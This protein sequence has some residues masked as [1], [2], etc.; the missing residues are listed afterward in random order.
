MVATDKEGEVGCFASS[1]VIFVE[2][3]YGSKLLRYGHGIEIVGVA[4]CLSLSGR[5]AISIEKEADLEI[6]SNN[7]E[8]NAIP[9]IDFAGLLDG[10]IDGVEG[11]MAL[12]Y[13]QHGSS[14]ELITWSKAHTALD[15]NPHHR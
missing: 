8:V 9:A 13:N 6:A 14:G 5:V 12:Q 2:I 11:A 15:C 10:G 1:A 4:D 7:E 3:T